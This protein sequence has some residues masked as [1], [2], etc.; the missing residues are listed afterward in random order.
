MSYREIE[1]LSD[2]EFK[3]LCGVSRKTCSAMV[4]V[5]DPALD[6]RRRK[7]GQAKLSVEDQ[8]LVALEY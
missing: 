1:F 4:E 3:R 7:G 2:G 8:Q 6:R 5:V